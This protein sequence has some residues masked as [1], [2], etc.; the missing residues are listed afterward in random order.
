MYFVHL[1]RPKEDGG[2]S[3]KGASRGEAGAWGKLVQSK[4]RNSRS[5][6]IIF[7]ASPSLAWEALD[8][9]EEPL[10]ATTDSWSRSREHAVTRHGRGP[11]W[12]VCLARRMKYRAAELDWW[13]ATSPAATSTGWRGTEA[14][15]RQRG[16]EAS[17]YAVFV[18]SSARGEAFPAGGTPKGCG[19]PD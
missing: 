1:S 17:F 8:E 11:S 18:A 6:G 15:F 14:C 5:S 13:C 9:T 10:M 12:L 7:L 19:C 2:P 16:C 4:L 3:R